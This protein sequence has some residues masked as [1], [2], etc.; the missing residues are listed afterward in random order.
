MNGN[1]DDADSEEYPIDGQALILATAKA[2]VGPQ[3]LPTL[4]ARVQA[5]LGPRLAEYR[6]TYECVHESP[7]RASFLV[8]SGRWTEVGDRLG[9]DRRETDAVRRTHAEQLRRVGSEVGRREELETALEI[10]EAVVIGVDG[11]QSA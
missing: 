3:R 9:F 2:S 11:G 4:L 7:E 8:P 6:R 10:R 5:E 1:E